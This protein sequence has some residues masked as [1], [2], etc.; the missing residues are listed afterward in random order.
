MLNQKII[1]MRAGVVTSA[2]VGR[3]G[4]D[5]D[6]TRLNTTP[7]VFL[8]PNSPNVAKIGLRYW[9]LVS[10]AVL[11]PGKALKFDF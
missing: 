4:W 2:H 5:T 8:Q 9:K 6:N 10:T 11:I 7:G 3:G 1:Y